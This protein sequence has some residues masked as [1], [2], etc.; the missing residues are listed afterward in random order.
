MVTDNNDNKDN[1]ENNASDELTDEVSAAIEELKAAQAKLEE[2]KSKAEAESATEAPIEL[3]AQ[4]IEASTVSD[5]SQ[6]TA[7]SPNWTTYSPDAAS[8]QQPAN[9]T[10]TGTAQPQTPQV[11]PQGYAAAQNAGYQGQQTTAQQQYYYQ[12]PYQQQI[13]STK[14]HVAAGLLAIFLGPLGIHKFYLG[15]NTAGFIMLAVSILGS[16]VTFSIAWWVMWV[17]AIIEGIMYLTKSQSDFEQI[18]VFNKREWF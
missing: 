8:V 6:T 2:V 12:P 13:V 10:T 5:Q 16:I 9:T 4:P 1:L 11:D 18:Y 7:Q 15:Y 3:E 17:I 14:D